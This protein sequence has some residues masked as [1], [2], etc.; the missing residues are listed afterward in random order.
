[1]LWYLQP[2]RYQST[3]VFKY[4]GERPA[5]EVLALLKS[6]SVFD[7]VC[8]LEGLHHQLE[9]SKDTAFEMMSHLVK[10]RVDPASGTIEVKVTHTRKEIGRDLAAGLPKALDAYEAQFAEQ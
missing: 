7:R 3:A 4:S 8:E 5:A 2:S 9:V 1:M 10:A 6:R